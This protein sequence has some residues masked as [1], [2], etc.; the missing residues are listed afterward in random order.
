MLIKSFPV[1]N[2]APANDESVTNANDTP[3][4]DNTNID[5]DESIYFF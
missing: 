1:N 3:T 4:E 5:Y 2:A